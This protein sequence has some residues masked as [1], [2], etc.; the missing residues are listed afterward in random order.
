M[1]LPLGDIPLF[2]DSSPRHSG[3]WAKPANPESRGEVIGVFKLLDSQVRNCA[4]YVRDFV[5]A[6]K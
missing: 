6:P 3:A 5:A 4:P 2:S 1:A